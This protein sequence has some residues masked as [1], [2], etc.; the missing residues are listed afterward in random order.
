M[1]PMTLFDLYVEELRNLYN[2][3]NQLVRAMPK[4]A[5]AASERQLRAA[6]TDRLHQT[7]VHLSRLEQV[8]DRLGI[9]PKG[10][11]SKVVELMVAENKDRMS[12]GSQP[13]VNDLAIIGAAQRLDHYEMACYGCVRHLASQLGYHRAAKLFT[14]TLE[15][16]RERTDQMTD[17]TRMIIS[18]RHR[19]G[20]SA[21]PLI[22]AGPIPASPFDD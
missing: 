12:A 7:Q 8:I 18:G 3:E 4:M 2:T 17:L 16:Q 10:R 19:M 14:T 9:G 20:S 1:K 5:K 6:L 15:E 11:E 21:A 13:S 22:M